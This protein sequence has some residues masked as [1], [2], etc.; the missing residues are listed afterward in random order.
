MTVVYL[1][2]SAVIKL[3]LQE[4]FTAEV[5]AAVLAQDAKCVTSDLTYAE[6]H[7]AFSRARSRGRIT[8]PQQRALVGSLQVWFEQVTHAAVTWDRV[9]R[10][11]PLAVKANLRG[12]DAIH[13]A[14]AI[15]TIGAFSGERRVFACF[16]ERLSMEAN[17]T[18]FFDELV[19]NPDWL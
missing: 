2:A 11:G 18:G 7:G 5:E 14:T 12:A 1:D 17:N 10:A 15:E 6:V 16:D 4:A 13:L 19:T 3:F 9:R 8:A